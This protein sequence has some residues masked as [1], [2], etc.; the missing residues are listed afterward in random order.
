[1]AKRILLIGT[2]RWAAALQRQAELARA[3]SGLRAK[4]FIEQTFDLIVVDAAS[5]YISGERVCRDLKARFPRTALILL[6]KPGNAEDASSADLI[7]S[8]PVTARQLSA[9]V[10]RLLS[11]D[12]R[13]IIRCGPF[14]LNRTTRTLLAHGARSQLSP[15]LAGL[16][17][18]FMLHPNETLPRV[19][20]M[21]RVWKT[22]Y[23]GDTRTLTVH[24]RH[25]RALLELAPKRPRYLK[26]LRGLGYR[27]EI[28]AQEE[29]V[30]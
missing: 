25:A 18:L 23:L 12:P 16:I 4:A 1:M 29:T 11:A 24:I 27:L 26:T 3:P 5:M 17:E 19:D 21:R 20:I 7:L 9:A 6:R 13:D 8:D 30:G 14:E 22:A 2:A 10:S 15:K 28:D